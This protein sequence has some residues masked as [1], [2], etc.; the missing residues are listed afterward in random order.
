MLVARA[1]GE[2]EFLLVD[3]REPGEAAIVAIDGAVLVPRGELL[4]G[5]TELP[6]GVPV[7]LH[8]KSGARSAE[9]LG[10][11]LDRGYE[12]RHLTGGILEWISRIE[13]ASPFTESRAACAPAPCLSAE[14]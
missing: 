2:T 9:V 14:K 3:V 11:L 13:P 10:H 12:A 7:V 4:S 6:R 8:C 5:E 1:A